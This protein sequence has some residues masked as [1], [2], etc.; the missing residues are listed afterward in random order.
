MLY[1]NICLSLFDVSGNPTLT[2]KL[3]CVRTKQAHSSKK[4][5]GAPKPCSLER[6]P[7][8]IDK[9]LPPTQALGRGDNAKILNC[10]ICY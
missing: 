4:Q 10:C 8:W 7:E 1:H 5:T 6:F 3:F 2:L 9:W